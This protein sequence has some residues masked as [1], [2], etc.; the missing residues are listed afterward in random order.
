MSIA[1]RARREKEGKTVTTT[2]QKGAPPAGACNGTALRKATRRVSQLYDA[3]LEPAGLRG[4]QR[5]ILIHIARAGEPA[6]G[7]LADLLVLDRSAL[8]HNL[9]PLERDGYVRV[10]VSNSDRRSRVA[11]LTEAGRAKLAE[12]LPLWERAQQQFE[13]A[14]GARPAAELRAALDFIASPAFA[15]A[16]EA[17]AKHP[18]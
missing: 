12:T 9:K 10:R 13:T 8:A 16:F 17:A 18:A 1:R 3:A 11:V 5:S 14:F 2:D 4:T 7:E 15:A 6:M